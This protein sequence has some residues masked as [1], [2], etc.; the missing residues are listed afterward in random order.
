MPSRSS[1]PRFRFGAFAHT[2]IAHDI[3]APHRLRPQILAHASNGTHVYE[4]KNLPRHLRTKM[5]NATYLGGG[6]SSDAWDLGD[7][8][9]LKITKDDVVVRFCEA[10]REQPVKGLPHTYAVYRGSAKQLQHG[11]GHRAERQAVR[12]IVIQQKYE[13]FPNELWAQVHASC[14]HVDLGDSPD[15]WARGSDNEAARGEEA[16]DIVKELVRVMSSIKQQDPRHPLAHC[17]VAMQTLHRWLRHHT[18]GAN[19]GLDIDHQDNWGIDPHGQPVLMDPLFGVKKP[20]VRS[21][22]DAYNGPS[23]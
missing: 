17:L 13:E 11:Q 4:L 14:Q 9:V 8:T 19:A 21:A 23:P 1:P 15:R 6:L 22:F 16:S 20:W 2:P 18:L 12:H 7:G 3:P 10:L 5:A